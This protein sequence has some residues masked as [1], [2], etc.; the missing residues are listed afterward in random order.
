MS[1]FDN[2]GSG[3]GSVMN[4]MKGGKGGKGGGGGE[5]KQQAPAAAAADSH[6][7]EQKADGAGGGWGESTWAKATG[8]AP[9]AKALGQGQSPA[10]PSKG[11]T[12]GNSFGE[13]RQGDG[14]FR[15]SNVVGDTATTGFGRDEKGGFK[16]PEYKNWSATGKSYGNRESDQDGAKDKAEIHSRGTPEVPTVWQPS[17]DKIG[18]SDPSKPGYDPRSTGYNNRSGVLTKDDAASKID[19][20][21]KSGQGGGYS[22]GGSFRSSKY[23]SYSGG[24][25]LAANRVNPETGKT[26]ADN[27][28]TVNHN[29][30]G[31]MG[32]A[33][34]E[35]QWGAEEKGGV[36]ATAMSE[37]KQH[38]A[39]AEAGWV[40]SGGASG[41]YGLDTAKGAYAQG[42]VGGKVGA[43]ASADADTK[44]SA[45]KIGGVDY[46]MGAGVHADAFVGAKAGASGEIGL[47]P[48]FIG[49]KGNI[50][51]F[52]GAEAAADVHGN[53]GPLGAKAGGSVMA[54]AGIGA[55]GDLS[56]KDGKFHVGGK[57][58]AALGYGGSLS[59]DMTVDVGAMGR[60]A[61]SLGAS[62][63]DGISTA[64]TAAGNAIY[65]GGTA[66][67]NAIYNGGAAA[68]NA[69]YNGGAVA[70]ERV[71][72]A[73]NATWNAGA[74]AVSSVLSW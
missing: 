10:A 14:D 30:K 54:G 50:G 39:T 74:S 72:N 23:G 48:D 18:N 45:V 43:Y 19:E 66:A 1:W 29:G 59:A 34:W 22:D 6:G 31:S 52:A 26:E 9:W 57:M 16:T 49:A 38:S 11:P 70:A 42:G 68:G 47:G 3:A 5:A 4:W 64:G 21:T 41:S 7:P 51:A 44:T 58:F 15:S 28:F 61:Y 32:I 17:L 12:G 55:E 53:L 24:T 56:Y 20:Q 37:N 62:A 67:G 13:I 40:A 27:K 33:G 63:A 65:N 69:I 71:G 46:D 2:I 35:G 36:R 73:A 8:L 25:G 60:S